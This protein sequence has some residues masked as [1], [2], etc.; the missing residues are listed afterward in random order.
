METI[1]GA[2]AIVLIVVFI[3]FISPVI[4]FA[5]GFMAGIFAKVTIGNSIVA[6]L[7]LLGIHISVGSIPLL[8]GVINLIASFFR[9]F[10]WRSS[11]D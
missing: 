7:A 5:M 2:I 4:Q 6:G 11:D 1:L 8:F 3:F 10:T 9:N